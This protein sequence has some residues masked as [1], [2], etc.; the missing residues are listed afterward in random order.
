MKASAVILAAGKG[1]RCAG[2]VPKQFRELGGRRVLEWA[3][4]PFRRC[5]QVEEIIVVVSPGI[6]SDPPPWLMQCADRLVRGGASRR[7][8]AGRGVCGVD[9][10]LGREDTFEGE[11]SMLGPSQM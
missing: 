2:E 5:D 6:F 4:S 10:C 11:S 8:S 1:S 3:C 7:E 9:P